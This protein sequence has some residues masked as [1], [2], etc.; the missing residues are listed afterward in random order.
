MISKFKNQLRA[1]DTQHWQKIKN[2]SLN[3]KFT[4]SYKKSVFT[5]LSMVPE[6]EGGRGAAAPPLPFCQEGQG[7][8]YCPFHFSATV[9][10]QTL[11]NL[12][13]RLSNAE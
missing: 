6:R 12:K 10:K 13:A 2:S 8:Q 5:V 1:T 7:G 11:T 3:S 4:G 9:A